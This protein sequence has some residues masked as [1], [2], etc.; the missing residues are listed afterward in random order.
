MGGI[1]LPITLV[2]W[3]HLQREDSRVRGKDESHDLPSDLTGIRDHQVFDVSSQNLALVFLGLQS[4]AGHSAHLEEECFKT[5]SSLERLAVSSITPYCGDALYSE[6]TLAHDGWALSM[7]PGERLAS[8]AHVLFTDTV[9]N[10]YAESYSVIEVANL[11]PDET[12]TVVGVGDRLCKGVSRVLKLLEREGIGQ[13][14]EGKRTSLKIII[15]EGGNPARLA[16]L[17]TP[18][19]V[20]LL[21]DSWAY[22]NSLG[23]E[24]SAISQFTKATQVFREAERLAPNEFKPLATRNLAVSLKK[25]KKYIDAVETLKAALARYPAYPD[26]HYLLGL[27]RLEMAEFVEALGHL[28]DALSTGKEL[29]DFPGD[30]G[31]GSYKANLLIAR[32]LHRLNLVEDS[33]KF[34]VSSVHVNPWFEPA[35]R[36]LVHLKDSP[37]EVRRALNEGVD[38]WIDHQDKRSI[39]VLAEVCKALGMMDMV[40]K[41]QQWA[42]SI[43][44]P[45]ISEKLS[46]CKGCLTRF[47]GNLI[48]PTLFDE[49]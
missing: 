42:D 5:I 24:Y 22:Y 44:E 17:G 46:R 34:I 7:W 23:L 40:E 21:R 27:I 37:N 16:Y 47:R 1:Y 32:I 38:L 12:C 31:S 15:P 25:S 41:Y 2:R 10:S 3:R 45:R 6:E 39:T 19:T 18:D 26:F 49:G 14:A 33:L 11:E 28:R 43:S 35:I 30:P 9:M 20:E 8:D 13:T 48:A 29:T 36:E 4:G